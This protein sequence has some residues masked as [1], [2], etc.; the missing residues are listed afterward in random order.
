MLE[1]K[2]CSAPSN[3]VVEAVA[4]VTTSFWPL[5][6]DVQFSLWRFRSGVVVFHENND[7]VRLDL[8]AAERARGVCVEP[9]GT[10]AC[11]WATA[12]KPQDPQTWRHRP[13]NQDRSF[14]PSATQT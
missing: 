1:Q 10:R 8:V 7:V 13:R 14:A 11:I 5:S 4:P 9:R 12:S 2:Q 6:I 3:E